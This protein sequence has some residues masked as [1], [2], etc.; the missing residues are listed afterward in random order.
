MEACFR[1]FCLSAELH[2][3]DMGGVLASVAL[4][5]LAVY[6]V[7]WGL[8]CSQAGRWFLFWPSLVYTTEYGLCE[9]L[10]PKILFFIFAALNDFVLL[11]LVTLPL[12][13]FAVSRQ[14]HTMPP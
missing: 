12:V 5:D 6:E 11:V 1:G 8:L 3:E 2:G 9:A 14:T 4:E 10:R 7:G 13:M